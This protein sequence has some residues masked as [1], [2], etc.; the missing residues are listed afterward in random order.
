MNCFIKS[1]KA[2]AASMAFAGAISA[3]PIA[4][5]QSYPNKQVTMVIPFGPGGSND[6]YG[7]VL[8]EKLGKLWNQT[9]IVENRAGAGSTIGSAHVAQAKPDGYT[10][11]FV[12][13]SY[14]TSAATQAKLPYDPLKDLAPIGVFANADLYLMTGKRVPL[15]TLQDLQKEA[16]AQKIFTG[17]PGVGSISHLTQLMLNEKLGITT[18]I[19]QHTSGG[20]VMTDMGGGRLDT[21]FGVVFEASN[22]AV[23]PVV[24]MSKERSAALPNVPTIVEAGY[25]DALAPLWFGVFAPAGTPKDII[26]KVNGDIIK[27]MKDP[28]SEE[29]LKAQGLKV[30]EMSPD[31]FGKMVEGDIK[32][33]TAL[34]EKNGLRK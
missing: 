31:E 23:T 28:G 5:A 12:S 3:S 11:L 18:D 24:V 7:R 33:W 21:Y 1:M 30:S 8:A 22:A 17:A 25:P 10:L 4:A 15:R 9:V 29:F 32:R 2:I 26:T 6:T 27:V 34:A 20:N 16:K 19:V 13:T 14:T